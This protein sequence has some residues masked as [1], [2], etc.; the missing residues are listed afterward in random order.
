MGT[1]WYRHDRRLELTNCTSEC[2][3]AG[4]KHPYSVT[5]ESFTGI[6]ATLGEVA[7]C[8]A[9]SVVS[10]VSMISMASVVSAVAVAVVSVVG[11]V[12]T[13]STASTASTASIAQQA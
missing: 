8:L 5:D 12:S 4:A 11:V 3:L 6:D 2:R 9:R 13:V 7:T 1:T 10:V